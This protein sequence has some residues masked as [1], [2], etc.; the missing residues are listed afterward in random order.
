MNE[1]LQSP[2]QKRLG[3]DIND[4]EDSAFRFRAEVRVVI[5]VQVRSGCSDV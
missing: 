3:P 2:R 4:G 5:R 1:E